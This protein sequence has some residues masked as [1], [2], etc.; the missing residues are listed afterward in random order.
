M[1]LWTSF[2]A[3]GNGSLIITFILNKK[4]RQ[5]PSYWF[6]ISLSSA[7]F[8]VGVLVL[9]FIAALEIGKISFNPTNCDINLILHIL[10]L[11]PT[12]PN[13]VA[14][15]VDR[16]RKF[17]SPLHYPVSM[18]VTKALLSVLALWIYAIIS[19][20]PLYIINHTYGQ[21]HC[22]LPLYKWPFDYLQIHVILGMLV[23]IILL[24]ASNWK[25]YQIASQASEIL[26][27]EAIAGSPGRFI[28]FY[29][30]GRVAI[31]QKG[32][33]E[34]QTIMQKLAKCIIKKKP[35]LLI[36]SIVLV[37]GMCWI[38]TGVIIFFKYF[39]GRI[40]LPEFY[41]W[42]I[43]L[44]SAFNPVIVLFLSHDFRKELKNLYSFSSTPLS[45]P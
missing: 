11:A 22:R 12:L 16:Y 37:S 27:E 6:I 4:L 43:Y 19:A 30:F 45:T 8:F 2:I 7:D 21:D 41:P 34:E 3:I 40:I 28:V 24:I 10:F 1:F 35:S 39:F 20:L 32:P 5:N 26:R 17:K 36:G 33:I 13:L 14:I 25:I 29:T 9:P 18:S 38:P 23:P 42:L 31:I 15:S 44:N